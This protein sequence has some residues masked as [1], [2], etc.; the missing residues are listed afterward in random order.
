[1]TVLLLTTCDTPAASV[2]L[3]GAVRLSTHDLAHIMQGLYHWATPLIFLGDV[4]GGHTHVSLSYDC[5]R[6]NGKLPT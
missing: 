4:C 3:L 1:M 6:G 5:C 2:S